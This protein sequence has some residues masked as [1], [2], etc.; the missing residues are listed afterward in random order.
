L[1]LNNFATIFHHRFVNNFKVFKHFTMKKFIA[2]M[3]LV[4]AISCNEVPLTNRKQMNLLPEKELIAMSLT[5]YN[6]FL[7]KNPP[8]NIHNA[9]VQMVKNVGMKISNAV[10]N[11]MQQNKQ[12]ERVKGYKW[13]FSLVNSPEV[14]AWCMPGGKVVVY[15]ALLPITKDETGLA[16][17]MGHEIAHAVARH[18]NERMSQMLLAQTGGIALDIAL[19]NQTPETR[20]MFNSAYGI[21]SQV[22]VLLPFSRLHETEADKLGMIFMALAGYNPSQAPLVWERMIAEGKGPKPLEI[23]STHPADAER[24]N[25]LLKFVPTA[26]KYYKVN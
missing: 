4:S 14:N 8:A 5:S 25:T 13:E 17:V 6:E 12:S 18:G 9:D 3:M 10:V 19:A 22:G 1:D 7:I 21:G 16:F 20:N 26:M 24:I 11:Y 2:A 23:L 15:S